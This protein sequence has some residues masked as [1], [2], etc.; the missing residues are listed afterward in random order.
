LVAINQTIYDHKQNSAFGVVDF[1]TFLTAPNPAAPAPSTPVIP[2]IPAASALM[3]TFA[4]A[5]RLIALIGLKRHR[6]K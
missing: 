5:S 2:E 6:K 1:L 3:V 4:V